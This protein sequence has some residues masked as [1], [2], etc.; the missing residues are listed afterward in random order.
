MFERTS[1]TGKLI[2]GIDLG[3]ETT[4][5]SVS[6]DFAEPE[7]VSV[8][9]NKGIYLV[10]TVLCVRNDTR[11]WIVGEEAIRCRNRN[12]GVFVSELLKKVETGEMTDIFGTDYSGEALL[13]RF[14]RKIYTAVHQSYLTD[15]IT[16]VV[17]TVRNK[18]DAVVAAINNAFQSIGT[19]M[20]RVV[21]IS[22]MESFMYY[23]ISQKKELWVNDVSLFDFDEEG[24]KYYQLSIAKKGLPITIT[25][26]GEDLSDDMDYGMLSD[27]VE[28]RLAGNF[29]N[30]TDKLLYRQIVSTMYFTG[31]G[32]DG[33]WADG[34]IKSL[35]IGRRVFKG[36]NLYSKG[37]AY[38]GMIIGNEDYKDYLFL[39]DDQ[40]RCTISIRMFKD[41][42]IGEV[43]LVDAGMPWKR[44]KAKTVGIV[45]DT[46]EIF[47][48]IFNAVRKETKHVVMNLKN[49]EQREN[50]TTRVSVGVKFLDRDTAVLTVK[51]LGFGEF[52]ENT[53]R[54]W[55]KVIE[56]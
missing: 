36:Q 15:E 6:R 1:G 16:R 32:F 40:V 52:F 2:I 54:I 41:N 21:V 45:D 50:K 13:E 47:F 30:I 10:P 5:L 42:R 38:A 7:S 48:T 31:V 12:A 43:R 35:C 23:T 34:I 53:Y 51:D 11:D 14:I 27:T 56:L 18:T 37:A 20:N 33:N 8:V 25:A 44:V 46:D 17:V 24:L 55:E 4:Q 26:R 49:L 22:Y 29:K 9:P 3:T 28:G 19:D 39:T